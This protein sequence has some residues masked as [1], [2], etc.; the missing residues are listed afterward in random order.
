MKIPSHASSTIRKGLVAA[1]CVVLLAT[2]VFPLAGLGV[3]SAAASS[4]Y[5]LKID[6]A[7]QD[8]LDALALDAP[9]EVVVVYSDLAA[10]PQVEALASLYF[11][12]ETLPMA[13]AVLTAGQIETIAAWPEIHSI[14]LNSDLEYFLAESVP[15]IGADQ[16]WAQYEETGENVTVAVVDTGIDATHPDLLFGEKVVQNVKF[17]PFQLAVENLAVTDQSSGHGTHVAGT[18]GGT[19]FVS[20][21]YYRGVAPNVDIVGLGAGETIGVLT[22]VQAYDW[23]L[24]HH[25]EYNIR[26]VNNSWGSSG[27]DINLRNPIVMATYAGYQAGILSVFASGNSGGYDIINP[28]SIAPWLLSVAAGKKNGALAE[29][30]SRGADGDFFKHPDIVA[31]GVDIYATRAQ[32]G[33]DSGVSTFPNPVNPLWTGHYVSMSGTSMA[34][35]HVVGAAALLFSGNPDLSPDQVMELL[36]DN[37]DPMPGYLFHEAGYGYMDVLAAFEESLT[38]TGNLPEFLT[39]EQQFS[40]QDVLGFDPD[41]PVPFDEY[42]FSGLTAVGATDVSAPIDH[43]FPVPEGTLYGQVA[44]EWT[45]QTEDAYDLEILDPQGRVV[46][47]SGNG[48]DIGEA[49][50][51]VPDVYGTYTLRLWPFAAVGAQYTASVTIAYGNQPENWPPN[52]PPTFDHY[53]GVTALY[54]LYGVLGIITDNFRSGDEAFLVFSLKDSDGVPVDGIEDSIQAI[55]TD[56]LGNV[57]FVDDAILSR[58]TVGEYQSSI[59]IDDGW[60]GVAGPTT[61]TFSIPGSG[62]L[63]ALPFVFNVNH[64]AVSLDTGAAQYEPGDPVDFSG[65]VE[66]VTTVLTGEVEQTPLAGATVTVSLLDGAGNP[67]AS[68]QASTDLFGAYSGSF[69][70]PAAASGRMTLVAAAD[71]VDPLTAIGP[72]DWYGEAQASLSFPGNQPPQVS[73]TATKQTDPGKK[74]FIHFEASASDPDGQ[75]DIVSLT[76]ILTDDKGRELN[77]WTLDEFSPNADGITWELE[78]GYK[79]SGRSPWTLTLTTVDSAGASATTSVQIER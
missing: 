17:L 42:E 9:L 45:P 46:V 44:V 24:T 33:A 2:G 30:S 8:Q 63:R 29:F 67:V 47:S 70:A 73:L 75:A 62:T 4:F 35:P 76:L 61:V 14:T 11:Q 48:L 51:F 43:T 21:G 38:V 5:D 32:I 41:A 37:A 66:Q 68:V 57:A 60:Q 18:I 27:G 58:S 16:V 12:M 74:N 64:L 26:V 28:Y 40:E 71:Y 25:E 55:Y 65:T 78:Q 56:R 13:G 49:A 79:V 69:T 10:A 77:R 50:L 15:L 72:A 7:L 39:G 23:I 53:L 34:T 31:P 52:T 20:D 36:I 1:L 19:G 6:P 54:K 22:A 59:F 3:P